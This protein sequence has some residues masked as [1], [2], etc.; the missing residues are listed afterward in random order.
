MGMTF[1]IHGNIKPQV[2]SIKQGVQ[3]VMTAKFS[4]LDKPKWCPQRD[5]FLL[6]T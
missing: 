3:V 6:L 4:V 2:I 1:R 5:L